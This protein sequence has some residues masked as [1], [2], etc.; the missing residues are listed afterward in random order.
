MYMLKGRR[1]VTNSLVALDSP[2]TWCPAKAKPQ[3]VHQTPGGG[4][5]TVAMVLVSLYLIC[6]ETASWWRG[7][8]MHTFAVEK[9]IGHVMQINTDMVVR[10]G[11]QD[12]HVN[13]QD[14][15][16]DRILAANML[17]REPTK[18]SQWVDG[19]GVHKLGRDGKGRV[20]TG[21]GWMDEEGFGK[22][23]V[24]DIVAAGRRKAQFA[25]TPLL[26][27][28]GDS[29]RVFG[30][31]ELNKVQGDFHITARGHGYEPFGDHLDHSG[32]YYYYYC[33]CCCCCC[34]CYRC[35]Y[36]LAGQKGGLRKKKKKKTRAWVCLFWGV[37]GGF[38]I[39]FFLGGGGGLRLTR[40]QQSLQLLPHHQRILVWAI[41]SHP[42]QPS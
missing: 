30:S 5:W 11:C 26:W 4:K 37:G 8:E 3:Y 6:S 38:A 16:G 1:F 32:T 42:R 2:P 19:K 29:C 10:M 20:V 31:L 28:K 23:H 15:A 17:R 22:E 35:Y 39:F 21:E 34:C 9:G 12:L 14:A 27:G 18:W 33:C 40:S 25:K 36:H 24:H 7:N 13:V 41:L